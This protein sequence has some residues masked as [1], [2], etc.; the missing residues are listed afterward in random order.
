MVGASQ[1]GLVRLLADRFGGGVKTSVLRTRDFGTTQP[2][3]SV[4][5]DGLFDVTGSSVIGSG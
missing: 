4:G 1:A 2:A 5:C 3:P